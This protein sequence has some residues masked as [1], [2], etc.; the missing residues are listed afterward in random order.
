MSNV[1]V[2]TSDTSSPYNSGDTPWINRLSSTLGHSL[3]FLNSI[4]S[5]P[6]TAADVSSFVSSNSLALIVISSSVTL[7]DIEPGVF[8]NL[9]TPVLHLEGWLY[10]DEGFCD[11]GDGGETSA[12]YKQITVENASHPIMAGL[13]GD[14]S[15][16]TTARKQSF[17][18]DD[19]AA[20]GQITFLATPKGAPTRHSIW[21]YEA[22]AL[23]ADGTTA[24]AERRVGLHWAFD[25]GPVTT[26]DGWSI[27]DAAVSWLLTDPTSSVEIAGVLDSAADGSSLT[28]TIDEGLA[29]PTV[30]IEAAFGVPWNVAPSS[31]DGDDRFEFD[32]LLTFDRVPNVVGAWPFGDADPPVANYGTGDTWSVISGSG[33]AQVD[34]PRPG[35]TA[36][37]LLGTTG[38]GE[39]ELRA[40]D[41]ALTG[42]FTFAFA[43]RVHDIRGSGDGTRTF[44]YSKQAAGTGWEVYIDYTGKAV[45]RVYTAA[46]TYTDFQFLT[47]VPVDGDWCHLTL[48]YNDADEQFAL[49]VD[50]SQFGSTQSQAIIDNASTVDLRGGS[51]WTNADR[52]IDLDVAEMMLAPAVLSPAS[53]AELATTA[54]GRGHY[55]S[56]PAPTFG[57][58]LDMRVKV[59]VDSW[60]NQAAPL[61]EQWGDGGS[62]SYE[63][64]TFVSSSESGSAD[65]F[66]TS[67][68]IAAPASIADGDLLIFTGAISNPITGLTPPGGWTT[69]VNETS[70]A[71]GTA[72]GL[73]VAYKIASSESGSYTFTADASRNRAGAIHVF[74]GVDNASPLDVT[75]AAGSHQSESENDETPANASITTVTDGAV[76]FL[77]G[78]IS[79]DDVT[80]AGAPTGYTLGQNGV[81]SSYNDRQFY[82]AYKTVATAG[83]ESPGSWTN[84]GNGT[85]IGD[86]INVTVALRPASSGAAGQRAFRF[87]LAEDDLGFAASDD[88]DAA[89]FE[90][91]AAGTAPTYMTDGGAQFWVRVTCDADNGASGSDTKFWV[92]QNDTDSWTQFGST[93]TDAVLALFDST[94]PLTVGASQLAGVS[95][96]AVEVLDA[97]D[98]SEVAAWSTTDLTPGVSSFSDDAAAVWTLNGGLLMT[99]GYDWT[100]L[101]PWLR[102]SG[103]VRYERGRSEDLTSVLSGNLSFTLDNRDRRFEPQYDGSPYYPYIT[104]RTPVRVTAV[105]QGASYELF[106][107]FTVR[108]E[109]APVDIGV[110]DTCEV[111]ATDIAGIAAASDID[112]GYLNPYIADADGWHWPL[113]ELTGSTAREV[114]TPLDAAGSISAFELGDDTFATSGVS[115]GQYPLVETE[116]VYFNP[117]TVD[118]GNDGEGTIG[119]WFRDRGTT[120]TPAYAVAISDAT[121]TYYTWKIGIESDGGLLVD[122]TSDGSTAGA[123]QLVSATDLMNG[124]WHYLTVVRTG[125]GTSWKVAAYVDGVS[126]ANNVTGPVETPYAG[127]TTRNAF[128]EDTIGNFGQL[129]VLN[130]ALSEVAVE[131]V[132]LSFLDTLPRQNAGDR[133][134]ALLDYL[135]VPTSMRNIDVGKSVM[136]SENLTGTN[137]LEGFQS[138]AVTEYGLFTVCGCGRASFF[139]R[140]TRTASADTITISAAGPQFAALEWTQ[141]DDYLANVVVASLGADGDDSVSAI[142]RDSVA[143]YGPRREQLALRSDDRAVAR[144]Y[145]DHVLATRS[146]TDRRV[147]QM[148]V[149]GSADHFTTLLG[150]ELNSRLR[151]CYAPKGGGADI[152]WYGFVEWLS[153]DIGQPV[154]SFTV[155]A[156]PQALSIVDW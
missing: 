66:G 34:G 67:L 135:G 23:L 113:D 17:I 9:A 32:G 110:D 98:G 90:H 146:A 156:S 92:R 2:I 77:S 70:P 116:A 71:A 142:D 20:V 127:P 155:R 28:V 118:L 6:V 96:L 150:M 107:G 152:D 105:W 49:Y 10:D 62:T 78:M 133:V 31:G 39:D 145:V 122:W 4:S 21:C 53:V 94:Q 101:T 87:T 128:M 3:S 143:L 130:E 102:L 117:T 16:T 106:R 108:W 43:V 60:P 12:T 37:R 140:G 56:T 148:T 81:G 83:A 19:A 132:Y 76:V 112:G 136:I 64:I 154:W 61:L 125:S 89:L 25:T 119:F 44:N 18:A 99:E 52:E 139:Q 57:T 55:L 141:P 72:R 82:T 47:A 1:G 65:V 68:T 124:A 40:D 38:T 79:A 26:A 91:T 137:L 129:S 84:T 45:V 114:L 73:C 33:H 103:G 104:A 59:Q 30:K 120:T 100:D 50:G 5:S 42:S 63:T 48:V 29:A 123:V 121:E 151:L 46:A 35:Q 153:V 134:E 147:R 97:I 22:G 111:T 115:V 14:V 80:A 69:V 11:R 93:D 7:S 126:V 85:N 41:I 149:L 74:R 8:E 51:S 54:L 24:A 109:P 131:E 27:F 13:S 58:D 36:T 88:G 144:S 86:S 75:F 95:I 138:A 15:V